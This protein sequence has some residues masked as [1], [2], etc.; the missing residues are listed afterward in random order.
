MSGLLY[1]G[2]EVE[3]PY[4]HGTVSAIRKCNGPDHC[5]YG[6][7]GINLIMMTDKIIVSVDLT[8]AEAEYKVADVCGTEISKI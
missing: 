8:D 2:D 7:N 1:I 5:I 6:L 3:T 4:G